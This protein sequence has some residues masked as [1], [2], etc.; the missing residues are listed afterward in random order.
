M[1]IL[2][3]A[4]VSLL[5][6]AFALGYALG[7]RGAEIEAFV[8]YDHVSDITRGK[9]WNKQAES[10]A[11]YVGAGITIAAGANRAWEI[12]I[13][14]GRKALD[15]GDTEAGSKLSVRFYPGRLQ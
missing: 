11:D 4:L 10:T 12:D 14:H 6:S 7:A 5:V 13:S 1:R 15:R 8:T 3:L 9:P 2:R